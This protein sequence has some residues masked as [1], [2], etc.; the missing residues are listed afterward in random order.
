M[1]TED[2]ATVKLARDFALWL[3]IEAAKHQVPMYEH[4]ENL[5]SQGREKRKPW[6]RSK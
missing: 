4:L 2:F 5:L 3:K 1:Q 6:R